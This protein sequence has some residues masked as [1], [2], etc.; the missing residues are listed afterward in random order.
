MRKEGQATCERG[1]S[2]GISQ[3]RPA[4]VERNDKKHTDN[5]HDS[6]H[7]SASSV[8]HHLVT[9]VVGINDKNTIF[10]SKTK[11]CFVST[12]SLI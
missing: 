5:I 6:S 12:T 4:V 8:N 10:S 9:V 2:M 11:F 1:I 7:Y 3:S